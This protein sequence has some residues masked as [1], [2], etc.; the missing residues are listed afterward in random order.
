MED[1][2]DNKFVSISCDNCDQFAEALRKIW[3][4]LPFARKT[5]SFNFVGDSTTSKLPNRPIYL[6]ENP[7]SN[8][9][10]SVAS[11]NPLVE[12]LL[13]A[14]SDYRDPC[15]YIDKNLVLAASS[16]HILILANI[17]QSIINSLGMDKN[18]IEET[19]GMDKL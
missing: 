6:Q 2:S 11:I 10:K 5:A 13:V 4:G 8:L 15:F 7:L 14:K 16:D 1:H 9:G 12:G 3:L 19:G 17:S 18:I